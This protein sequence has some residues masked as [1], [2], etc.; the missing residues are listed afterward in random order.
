MEQF[1][2]WAKYQENFDKIGK[3]ADNIIIV[4][5][6]LE[7]SD[8]IKIVDYLNT[9]REDPEFS[10]GKDLRDSQVIRENPEI[11]GFMKKYESEI[12]KIATEHF[13]NKYGIELEQKP[14]NSLHFVKWSPDMASGLHSDCQHPNGD[15]LWKGNYYKLNISA[16]IYPNDDYEGGHITF[17]SYNI[18]LKPKA[19]TLIIFPSN[20][21]YAHEVTRVGSGIRYTMPLWFTFKMNF[22]GPMSQYKQGDSK[23]L[24]R[25]PGEDDSDLRSY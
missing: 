10:G 22:S 9:H 15:P 4:E 1:E 19:G 11:Y 5:N 21:Y 18:D 24:W 23:G 6:F 17:P 20:N 13:T 12:Y 16:L 25:N 7:E 8:R 14:W 3:S 2:V